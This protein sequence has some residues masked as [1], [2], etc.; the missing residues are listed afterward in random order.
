MTIVLMLLFA[1]PL[2]RLR[3][4]LLPSS[5]WVGGPYRYGIERLYDFHSISHYLRTAVVKSFCHIYLK[6]IKHDTDLL[7]ESFNIQR[8]YEE[9]KSIDIIVSPCYYINIIIRFIIIYILILLS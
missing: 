3:R 5:G 8:S 6:Q 7:R 1:C 4:N 2:A 9:H